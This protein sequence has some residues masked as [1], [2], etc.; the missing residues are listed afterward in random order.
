MAG[1]KFLPFKLPKLPSK[2]VLIFFGTCTGIAGFIYRDRILCKERKK[3]VED[4]VAVIASEPLD[5][6]DFPPKV[7]VYL[8]PPRGDGIHKT[9]VH[10]RE[11]VKVWI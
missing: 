9:R 10:F 2:N 6:H 11:Y 7:T 3:R 5:V 1:I 8:A 4:R